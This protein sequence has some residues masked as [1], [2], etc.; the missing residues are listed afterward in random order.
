MDV[1]DMELVSKASVNVL[2]HMLEMI[3]A[4][5]VVQTI[6]QDM[7]DV[8]TRLTFVIVKLFGVATIVLRVNILS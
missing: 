1:Q 4:W 8:I 7:E 5:E 2:H 6:V 3:V